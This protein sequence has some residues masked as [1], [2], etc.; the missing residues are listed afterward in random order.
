LYPS[1]KKIFRNHQALEVYKLIDGKYQLQPSIALLPEGGEMVWM[2]EICLGIGCEQ[3]DRGDWKRAWVYWYDRF[4]TRYPTARERA[5]REYQEK[6]QERF[7]KEQAEAA[8]RIL[9][10]IAALEKLAKQQAEAIAEQERLAKE[11]AE[12]AGRILKGIAEQE[13]LIAAQERQEKERLAVY[14][15]SLG[16]NPDEI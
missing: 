1:T 6:L 13:R 12:A 9:K 10:G 7:A 5:L 8:G 3:G 16:I 11:N 15:R 2:P 4:G 14:L